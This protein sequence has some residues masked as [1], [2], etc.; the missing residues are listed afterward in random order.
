MRYIL[1]VTLAAS[2]CH[3]ALLKR[4]S[5]DEMA[6]QSSAIVHG[7]IIAS[8]VE[9]TKSHSAIMT[10]Y[11]VEPDLYLKGSLGRT[12][13]LSEPGGTIGNLT[14]TV[15]GAPH[16]GSNEE[17][18]LFVWTHPVYGKHQ[19]IGLGQGVYRVRQRQELAQFLALVS[20]ALARTRNAK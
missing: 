2:L 7:R 6:A 13:E 17:V 3:A 4:L 10:I 14:Y 20:Q 11:T 8:R 16:F 19:A 18:I 12:F 5:M 15:A 1:S 9:W